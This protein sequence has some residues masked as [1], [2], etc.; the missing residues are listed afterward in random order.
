VTP[1]LSHRKRGADE[2]LYSAGAQGWSV[3]ASVTEHG[4][5][6]KLSAECKYTALAE[7]DAQKFHDMVYA[8]AIESLR[9]AAELRHINTPLFDLPTG[10]TTQGVNTR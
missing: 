10:D 5:K 6:V 1:G 8:A 9:Q 2:H 7:T 4:W 3:K